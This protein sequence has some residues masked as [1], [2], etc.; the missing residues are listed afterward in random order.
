MQAAQPQ[1]ANTELI[2][3]TNVVFQ[4]TGYPW[5][6]LGVAALWRWLDSQ[7]LEH[8]R[9]ST[10]NPV[11]HYKGAECTLRE[12]SLTISGKEAAVYALLDEALKV[13]RQS[14][15][16]PTKKGNPGLSSLA[17]MVFAGQNTPNFLAKFAELPSKGQWRASGECSECGHKGVPTRVL[18]TSYNPLLV[19]WDDM[20][21]FYSELRKQSGFEICQVCAFA[22]PFA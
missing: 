17:R 20:A 19:G 2:D 3:T 10:G 15:E 11:G 8:G 7:A 1:K 14:L 12:K 5:N 9:D 4:H 21:G 18:G 16:Q 6:D 13:L 22:T